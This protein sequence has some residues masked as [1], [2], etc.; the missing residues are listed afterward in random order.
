MQNAFTAGI[1]G[2]LPAFRYILFTPALLARLHKE[3]IEAILI[4]EIGHNRYKHLLF[5]PFILTGILIL[6]AL[7]LSLLENNLPVAFLEKASDFT[8]I[9]GLFGMY[10]LLLG[11]YFRCIFGSF[12]PI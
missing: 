12:P 3:E 5:Y 4:H 8:L 9:L 10:A 2:V 1:I 11:L 6:S 7:T